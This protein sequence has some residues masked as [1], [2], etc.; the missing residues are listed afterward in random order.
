MLSVKHAGL[1]SSRRDPNLAVSILEQYHPLLSQ[2]FDKVL[3]HINPTT[4]KHDQPQEHSKQGSSIASNVPGESGCEVGVPTISDWLL[5]LGSTN[6]RR[7]ARLGSSGS[8]WV[9]L[10]Y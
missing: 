2:E 5:D 4:R 10:V 9:V 6:T 8:S 1:V 7:L 3:Q